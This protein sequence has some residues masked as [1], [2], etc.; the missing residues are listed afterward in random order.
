MFHPKK[1]AA[2]T[3][4]GLLFWMKT[5]VLFPNEPAPAE[6]LAFGIEQAQ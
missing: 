3:L 5:E 4:G 6:K 2:P 1:Q